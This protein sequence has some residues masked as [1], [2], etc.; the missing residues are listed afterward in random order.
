[1]SAVDTQPEQTAI[2]LAQF[3]SNTD[4]TQ[5]KSSNLPRETAQA[6]LSEASGVTGAYMHVHSAEP[7][8]K[9]LKQPFKTMFMNLLLAR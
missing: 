3:T 9:A 5:G 8:S 2:P 1:M 6:W 4:A 7:S